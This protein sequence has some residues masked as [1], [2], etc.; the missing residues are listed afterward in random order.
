MS[1]ERRH[2]NV[3]NLGELEASERTHGKFSFS[4]KHP[5]AA[6]DAQA[7]GASW[8]EIPPGKTA[9]PHH[10][11]CANEESAFIL[12][13]T[14]TLRIGNDEVAVRAGD[15]MTFPVGKDHPHQLLNTGD[16]P[17]R[18]LC[19][20]TLVS[21]EVVGYPDSN[22]IAAIASPKAYADDRW[23]ASWFP[24]DANVGYFHGEDAEEE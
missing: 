12:E 21:T 2:P 3:V 1:D 9:F 5:G 17:L 11:H 24:A 15:Y 16:T 18:Y 14:G 6:T 23:V 4:T 19:F 8:Y 22:K 13:G 7:I 20:S 10:Y